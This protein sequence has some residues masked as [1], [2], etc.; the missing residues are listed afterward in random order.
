LQLS[1]RPPPST[2]RCSYS[3]ANRP[4][5]TRLCTR[6][7]CRAR[8]HPLVAAIGSTGASYAPWTAR[9]ATPRS[10]RGRARLWQH[11][12]P[13]SACAVSQATRAERS[14]TVT[15]N[16]RELPGGLVCLSRIDTG[17][18]CALG[19]RALRP[20]PRRYQCSTRGRRAH[21][22]GAPAVFAFLQPGPRRPL[23]RHLPSWHARISASA[24]PAGSSSAR[25][26]SSPSA[27]PAA[28]P[29]LR[30]HARPAVQHRHAGSMVAHPR[31]CLKAARP[32]AGLTAA[33]PHAHLMI[34][35]L[36]IVV[37]HTSARAHATA[38]RPRGR[39][40]RASPP[41][42]VIVT[43]LSRVPSCIRL[44]LHPHMPTPFIS[45][46]ALYMPLFLCLIIASF[47]PSPLWGLRNRP[48]VSFYSHSLCSLAAKTTLDHC[49]GCCFECSRRC[50][51]W[52]CR[53]SML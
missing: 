13:R 16:A 50:L 44:C 37:A 35:C 2:R 12:A 27:R 1:A 15:L 51:N 47:L 34:A 30:Q 33:R 9:R 25:P 39:Y 43:R 14:P 20:F 32:P 8:K 7:L 48:C 21:A 10:R 53:G 52:T 40:R 24:R 28:Q 38:A 22:H 6:D 49:I 42:G 41:V 3:N 4:P 11:S 5:H 17:Y 31:T 45:T 23:S 36:H 26:T 19:Q 46:C 29:S 18:T